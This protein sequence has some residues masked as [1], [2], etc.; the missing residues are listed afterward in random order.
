M[1]DDPTKQSEETADRSFADIL[2]EFETATRPKRQDKAPAKGKGRQRR[3]SGPPPLR[4]TVVGVSGDFVLIDYGGKSEGVIAAVDLRDPEG[5]L[6]SE[7]R[8][9]GKECRS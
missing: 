7:E 2:N 6:R 8:R 4:G 9:V 5:N 1:S 3:P